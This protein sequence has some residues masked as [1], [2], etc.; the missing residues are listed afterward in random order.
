MAA[1]RRKRQ[2]RV[3][4]SIQEGRGYPGPAGSRWHEWACPWCHDAYR[5]MTRDLVSRWAIK[6]LNSHLRA[7]AVRSPQQAGID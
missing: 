6:H 5:S 4:L 7:A 3:T 1:K 2:P